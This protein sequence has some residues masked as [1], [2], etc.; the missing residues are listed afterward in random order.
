M[1]SWKV[2]YRSKD[3]ECVDKYATLELAVEATYSLL[4]LGYEV[5]SIGTWP[6]TSMIPAEEIL[7]NYGPL[8]RR[9]A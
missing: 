6:F 1:T 2:C 7:R 8:R 9:G 3:L 4:D 5:V